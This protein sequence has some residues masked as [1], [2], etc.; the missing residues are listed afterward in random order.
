MIKNILFIKMTMVLFVLTA[1]TVNT[2]ESDD[3]QGMLEVVTVDIFIPETIPSQ[4]EVMLQIKVNQGDEDVEDAQDVEF[5]IWKHHERDEGEMIA[6]VH[7]GEGIYQITHTFKKDGI[8]FVQT[9]VTARDM[10]VMPTKQIIVGD[11]SE[12]ELE[13]LK[14]DAVQT[15]SGGPGHH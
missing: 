6:G 15:E 9:H 11:V 5:E 8:Y 14:D 3:V 4:E 7:Q 10:H 12:E 13:S 1:C 2:Q